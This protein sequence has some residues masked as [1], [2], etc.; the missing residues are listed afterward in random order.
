MSQRTKMRLLQ[1]AA[2]GVFVGT[3]SL[4]V[5]A[6]SKSS[7]R[8]IVLITRDMAFF[9]PGSPQPNPTLTVARGEVVRLRL[10]NED[11]GM[12][13]DW[14]VQAWETS[15]RLIGGGSSDSIVFTAPTEP[16]DHDYVCSTHA[17]LMRGRLEVR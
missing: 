3:L 8:E 12:L 6:A 2:L 13:H 14:A 4:A 15:T 11:R 17:V 9:R 5:A 7:P 10:V 16:G 1:L